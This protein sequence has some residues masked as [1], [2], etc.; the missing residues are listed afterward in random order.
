MPA[1]LLCWI[2]RDHREKIGLHILA[3]AY[4]L[5]QEAARNIGMVAF[6]LDPIDEAV[7]GVWTK[8]PYY[9]QESATKRKSGPSRLWLPL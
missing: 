7:A 2:A 9:F 1:F 5:A 8:H 6:A 3:T 4:G